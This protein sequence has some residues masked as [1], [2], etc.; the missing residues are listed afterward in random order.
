[1]VRHG[2]FNWIIAEGRGR[3]GQQGSKIIRIQKIWV[4]GKL[5]CRSLWKRR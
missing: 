2:A 4:K 3:I 5:T 1:M